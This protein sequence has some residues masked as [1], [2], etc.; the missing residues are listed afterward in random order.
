MFKSTYSSI[1]SRY[2]YQLQA[3]CDS[4]ALLRR[5]DR[6]QAYNLPDWYSFGNIS[7]SINNNGNVAFKVLG[8]WHQA[9]W[10]G[11]ESTGRLVYVGPKGALLGKVSLNNHECLVWEQLRSAGGSSANSMNVATAD[12]LRLANAT[13]SL[14]LS[15]QNGIWLYDAVTNTS[16]LLT[17]SP[18][19]SCG[20]ASATLNDQG[21]VGF[22]AKFPDGYAFASYS[23]TPA[24]ATAILAQVANLDSSSIYSFLFMPSFNNKGQIA[25]KV[26]LGNPGDIGSERP[27]QI[28]SF[29]TDGDSKLIVANQNYDADSPYQSFDN[30]IGFN[31]NGQIAFTAALSS[32]QRGVFRFDGRKTELIA[33]EG[34]GQI[35]QIERFPPRLNN[36]GLIVFRAFDAEGLRTIWAGDGVTLHKVVSEGDVLPTD[37]GALRLA[38]PDNGP[39]FSGLPDL[40]DRGDIVFAAS[41]SDPEDVKIGFGAG[42]FVAQP[43]W[44]VKSQKSR[45]KNVKNLFDF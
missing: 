27:D 25:A 40:N 37:L 12:A 22:R 1:P 31:D 39:V 10:Y 4:G 43:A 19:G 26:R 5:A 41:L 20:W 21:D 36:N 18:L 30:S 8:A 2:T 11:T 34:D 17:T 42:L 44:E 3:R 33:I 7:P 32:G 45:V 24:G 14:T 6:T 29:D 28:R 38:R 15:R 23:F 9:I 16:S 13:A 35:S